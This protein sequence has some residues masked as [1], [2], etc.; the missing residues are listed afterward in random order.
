MTDEPNSA[1]LSIRSSIASIG[2][3]S[4]VL[5]YSLQYV[6]ARLHRRIG[7]M[8]TRTGCFVEAKARVVC[9]TPRTNLL[10]L[11]DCGIDRISDYRELRRV[12]K[13]N[14]PGARKRP[15][16]LMRRSFILSSDPLYAAGI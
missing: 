3:G 5:S 15:R 4:L 9:L 1:S 12:Y 6:H 11:L 8:C 2:T 14:G 10:I 16:P 7:T 13:I